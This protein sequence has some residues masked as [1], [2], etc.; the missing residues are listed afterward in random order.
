MDVLEGAGEAE[1]DGG[2]DAG[3]HEQQDGDRRGEAELRAVRAEREADRVAD[4]DVGPT[5]LR[6]L[7]G[8]TGATG[9]QGLPGLDGVTGATGLRGLEGVTGATGLQGLPGITGP[10]GLQGLLGPTGSTGLAGVTG[11]TGLQGLLGPTGPTGISGIIPGLFASQSSA[12]TVNSSN[13]D[14]LTGWTEGYDPD[15][16]FNASTGTFTAPT[17]GDYLVDA[18]SIG[19]PD[20]AVTLSQGAGNTTSLRI[21]KNNVQQASAQLPLLNVA[22]PLV[23]TL[24]VPLASNEVS[25]SAVVPMSAGDTIKVAMA[26]GATMS[27]SFLGSLKI[28]PLP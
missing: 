17:T 14:T 24:R 25:K 20:S 18:S 4:E 21:L 28:T 12:Q 2:D 19:G 22:V 15:D 6:G 11:A 16:S 8:V 13:T 10:T 23:L 5:G 26:N 9:L 27:Q 1:L 7:E 3:E